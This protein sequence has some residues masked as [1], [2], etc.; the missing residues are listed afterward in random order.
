M[1]VYREA[2]Y[3]RVA[4][5][6]IALGLLLLV[7]VAVSGGLPAFVLPSPLQVA[8]AAWETRQLLGRAV[9]STSVVTM[10][11]LGVAIVLGFCAGLL[12]ERIALLRRALY[13]LLTASQTI[14]ILAVAPLIIVWFGFGFSSTLVIV[15]LFTFFPITVA[16]IQGL[17]AVNPVQVEL[18]RAMRASERRIYRIVRIP[19]ALPSLFSG[20]RLAATYSVVAATIGEWVGGIR[21]LGLYMLRSRNALQ[22]DRL[23]AGMLVTALL[24]VMLFGVVVLCEHLCMPWFHE[25]IAGED[26]KQ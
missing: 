20:L 5:S 1:N 22:T 26:A 17:R 9:A 12:I 7:W 2:V 8:R 21:G 3:K 16:I 13:P 19:S 23:F 24:S 25:R 11:G 6:L 14:Q 10:A 15:I 4:P 18:L